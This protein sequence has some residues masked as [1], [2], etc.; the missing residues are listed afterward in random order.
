METRI[1]A[2][3]TEGFEKIAD[4]VEKSG[5]PVVITEGGRASL[6]VMSANEYMSLSGNDVTAEEDSS[7]KDRREIRDA[8]AELR[9]KYW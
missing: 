1:S 2:S 7:E 4:L 3:E 8:L 5:G 6:V 9:N